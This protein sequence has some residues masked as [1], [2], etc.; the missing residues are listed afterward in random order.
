MVLQTINQPRHKLDLNLAKA[1]EDCFTFGT[2]CLTEW[3]VSDWLLHCRK[4]TGDILYKKQGQLN[5]QV[6]LL[7]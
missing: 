1:S 6:Q 4:N 2:I 5:E 3:N 7:A